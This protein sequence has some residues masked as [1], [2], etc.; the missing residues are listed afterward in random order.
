MLCRTEIRPDS[1]WRS[2]IF[3]QKA[4]MYEMEGLY[5]NYYLTFK[6]FFKPNTSVQ[7]FIVSTHDKDGSD[8]ITY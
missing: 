4:H 8:T 6:L 1:K 3:E 5:C 2:I 7:P